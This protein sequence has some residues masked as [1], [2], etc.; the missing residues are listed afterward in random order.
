MKENMDAK[1]CVALKG[2]RVAFLNNVSQR[3]DERS[4]KKI[5]RA[6]EVAEDA[7]TGQTRDDDTPYILHPLRIAFFLLRELDIHDADILSAALLHD[8][9]EDQERFTPDYIEAEFGARV[10]SIVRTLTKP[11]DS[12]KTREQINEVYFESLRYSDEDC[13]LI[14]LADKLDNIR[15]AVNCPYPAKQQR[16]VAEAKGFYLN[17]LAA[18]LG[19]TRR[20]QIILKFMKKAIITLETQLGEGKN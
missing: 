1:P 12:A 15:D 17:S 2:L 13:K 3:F 4:L 9:A 20:K 7:H 5:T 18:S 6:L 8:V 11:S 10:S 14:K 16:T 19:D